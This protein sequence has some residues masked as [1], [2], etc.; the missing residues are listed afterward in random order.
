MKKIFRV[1][2]TTILS[3]LVLVIVTSCSI[4]E[5]LDIDKIKEDIDK[6]EDK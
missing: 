3:A 4:R 1:V 2:F 6:E 5:K